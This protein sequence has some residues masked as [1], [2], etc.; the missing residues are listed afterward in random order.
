MSN[1]YNLDEYRSVEELADVQKDV[2][3]EITKLDADAAGVPFSDEQRD[4]FAYLTKTDKDIEARKTELEARRSYIT[5]MSE[6]R[7]VERVG[8]TLER[9]VPKGTARERDIFDLSTIRSSYTDPGAATEE[10][11]GRSLKAIEINRHLS[12]EGRD[13]VASLIEDSPDEVGRRVLATG[14]PTYQRAFVKYLAQQPM[15]NEEARALSLTAAAGG[16][17]VPYDLDPTIIPTSDS[18]VN[19]IRAISRVVQ[20]TADTWRGVSSGAITA[21]YA[22]EATETTDNSPTLAQPEISTEKAQAFV[23]FSIEIDMDWPGMRAEMGRLLAEA[24]DDL[25]S[26]KFTSGT[27]TNEPFGLLVG[28]TNN[29]NAA[30]GQTFTVANLFSLVSALPP[31]Y[32]ARASFMGNLAVINRIRQFDTA[33]GANLWET[34]ANDAPSRLL[35]RPFY[36]NSSMAD[37]ATGVEFLVYGDFTRFVIV[38]RVGLNIEVLPHLLGSNRRPTGQRGLY[39]Y[40]RNGSKVVD[41][42]AFRALI[43]VA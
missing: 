36:E 3:G 33:G 42:N 9:S 21:S 29:V 19:P 17:A 37:V 30:A 5:R 25:E 28:I 12:T 27:G 15:T 41:A 38:D 10:V 23:P 11:R 8:D 24:K 22:A 31:R 1:E 20:T 34:L 39:A 35:G 14:S 2:R 16:Y 13:R 6:G 7:S 18:V 43:G 26:A 32:R 40:W 4:R